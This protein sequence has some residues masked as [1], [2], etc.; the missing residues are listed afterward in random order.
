MKDYFE[1]LTAEHFIGRSCKD[2]YTEYVRWC[3]GNN[4]D[5]VT[6]CG[7]GKELRT[8]YGLVSKHKWFGEANTKYR[9][10]VKEQE[11]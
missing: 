5:L 1:N 3:V 7:F 2:C 4:V 10:Y 11:H 6:T 8:R 9:I